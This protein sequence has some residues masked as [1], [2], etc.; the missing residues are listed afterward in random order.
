MDGSKLT[1]QEIA[2]YYKKNPK[3]KAVKKREV[4]LSWM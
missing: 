2:V 1:G 4:K 3:A